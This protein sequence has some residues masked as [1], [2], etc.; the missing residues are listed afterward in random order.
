MTGLLVIG[1]EA[2][3]REVL[4]PYLADVSLVVAADSG[5]RTALALGLAVDMVVGD[6]DSL[7]DPRLL[8]GFDP[9]C[10]LR[11]PPDKDETDTEIG[12]R[13]L[14]ERGCDRKIVA[15]GGGGRMD[16]FLGV[17]MLFERSSAPAVWVTSNTV[18]E[19][20]QGRREIDVEVGEVLSLFPTGQGATVRRSR[21]LRWPLDGMRLEHGYGS[22]S[23]QATSDKIA[24]EI[25]WGGLIL[26]RSIR[27][28]TG[29]AGQARGVEP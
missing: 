17:L 28:Q 12:I 4:D 24:L 7:S 19:L 29:G 16:H 2:P 26:V 9:A 22:L 15:G 8:D 11:F 18:L 21:G 5:L 14:G 13:V 3:T 1:G 6:M 23:N 25:A 20:V 27:G 10:V